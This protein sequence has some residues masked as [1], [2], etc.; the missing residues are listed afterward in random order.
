MKTIDFRKV[1][2]GLMILPLVLVSCDEDIL[3][4]ISG[5]GEIVTRNLMLD[6]FTGFSNTIAA[7]VFISQGET[8]EVIIEAQENII[9]NIEL[10]RVDNGFWTIRNDRWVRTSKWHKQNGLYLDYITVIGAYKWI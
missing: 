6:E 1:W 4:G 3:P 2:I 7:D 9:D 8:Q 10:D 5:E